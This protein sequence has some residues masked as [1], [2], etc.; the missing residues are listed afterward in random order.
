MTAIADFEQLAVT[1]FTDWI[2]QEIRLIRANVPRE[3]I[4]LAKFHWHAAGMR[5]A[6]LLIENGLQFEACNAL[7]CH[8]GVQLAIDGK[9]PEASAICKFS[10]PPQQG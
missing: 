10:S 1:F 7:M 5:L 8:A 2:E 4:L 3:Q 9:W 6:Q